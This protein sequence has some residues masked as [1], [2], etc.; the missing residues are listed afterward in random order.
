MYFLNIPILIVLGEVSF[1]FYLIHQPLLIM[2]AQGGGFWFLGYNILPNSLA[3]LFPLSI[4]LA[5]LSYYL[6]EKPAQK[7]IKMGYDSLAGV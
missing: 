1:G 4:V 7:Y 3:V 6:V 2:A 5:S